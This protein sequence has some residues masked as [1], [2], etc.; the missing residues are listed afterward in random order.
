VTFCSDFDW[1]ASEAVSLPSEIAPTSRS[2]MPSICAFAS[3]SSCLA[4]R[5][6][7]SRAVTCA[8]AASVVPGLVTTAGRC[9]TA[10]TSRASL[11]RTRFRS[12][13]EHAQ[14]GERGCGCRGG[15][16]LEQL[17]LQVSVEL[18]LEPKKSRK[19]AKKLL[20]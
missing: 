15:R 14:S 4:S 1:Q 3:F 5:M 10:R 13:L 9:S 6:L 19:I 2:V 20:A 18:A 12:T 16:T 11:L 17:Q 7:A 8:A